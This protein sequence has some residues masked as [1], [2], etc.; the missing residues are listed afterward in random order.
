MG[1]GALCIKFPMRPMFRWLRCLVH[2]RSPA[3]RGNTTAPEHD[4]VVGGQRKPERETFV[5]S[6][7][8]FIKLAGRSGVLEV[9]FMS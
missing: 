1:K 4:A 8:T 5:L 2:R 3:A 7:A 9:R 6:G